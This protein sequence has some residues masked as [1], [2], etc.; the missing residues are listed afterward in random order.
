MSLEFSKLKLTQR[1][2]E[3]SILIIAI[4]NFSKYHYGD[5]CS[6]KQITIGT[7]LSR[8]LTIRSKYSDIRTV[9][10]FLFLQHVFEETSSSSTQTQSL[11]HRSTQF[12][13]NPSSSSSNQSVNS[14]RVNF[15]HNRCFNVN[16][17]R[18]T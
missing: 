1:S 7:T 12:L 2:I 16:T 6:Y 11:L 13:S 10:S 14:E 8:T 3:L 18:P 15:P 4:D 9:Y 17:N 5:T